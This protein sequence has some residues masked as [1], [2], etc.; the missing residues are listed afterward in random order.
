MK[1][2]CVPEKVVEVLAHAGR[3]ISLLSIHNAVMSV[4][5]EISSKIRTEVHTL[6]AAFTYNNFNIT[7]K[8]SQ[9]TLENWSSFV[10]ATSATVVPLFGIDE[11]NAIALKYSAELWA[12][13]HRNPLL[14]VTLL[15]N[16]MRA[17]MDLHKKDTYS[18]QINPTKPSP[19]TTAFG[20]HV[21]AILV[22]Q[23]QKFKHFLMDLGEPETI[24]RIP[25]LTTHQI[26]CHA[27]DIKQLMTDG[28]VKV[29]EYLF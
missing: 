20:W 28:N 27:M 16:K 4:S 12:S 5:K 2:T 24:K 23:H 26:P 9:P 18:C 13:D 8:T 10:S 25:I 15:M 17:M 14:L 11:S 19:R 29:L 22:N 21:R 7:F 6:R 3:L 1:S